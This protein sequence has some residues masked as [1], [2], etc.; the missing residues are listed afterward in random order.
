MYILNHKHIHPDDLA[1]IFAKFKESMGG[2]LPEDWFTWL[3]VLTGGESYLLVQSGSSY[4]FTTYFENK[5]KENGLSFD[6]ILKIKIWWCGYPTEPDN[7]RGS[8]DRR[9]KVIQNDDHDQQN[10]GSSSRDMHDNG[11]V[12]VKGC[13]PNSHRNFELMLFNNPPGAWN[14]DNDYPIRMVLSSYYFENNIMSI[15]DGLSD[16]KLC[17][18]TCQYCKGR[19]K[20]QAYQEN[21]QPYSGKGYT[22]VHRDN[23]IIQAMRRWMHI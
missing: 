6:D 14:N 22:Y 15:P 21:A 18:E 11:C 17:K 12:L 4:S 16:C 19:E 1:V 5:L 7:D 20:I 9:R 13:P 2:S 23:Q 3:E 10:P 8:L